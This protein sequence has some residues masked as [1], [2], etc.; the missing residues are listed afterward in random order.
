[1]NRNKR[2]QNNEGNIKI[3]ILV[4][5]A[6]IIIFYNKDSEIMNFTILAKMLIYCAVVAIY[7]LVDFVFLKRK[8]DVIDNVVRGSC[9]FFVLMYF[10]SIYIVENSKSNKSAYMEANIESYMG[11]R[12]NLIFFKFKG[13]EYSMKFFNKEGISREDM[14]NKY[15]IM[16]EYRPSVLNTFVIVESTLKRKEKLSQ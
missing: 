2:K 6:L 12:S 8:G 13:K 10:F 14:V 3:E 4:L 7:F 16:V 9:V 15:N 11:G 5:L 1:M